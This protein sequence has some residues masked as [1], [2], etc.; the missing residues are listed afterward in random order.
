M[1]PEEGNENPFQCSCLV[2]PIDREVH[3]QATVH[4]VTKSCIQLSN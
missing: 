3:R 4:G 1:S 2:N